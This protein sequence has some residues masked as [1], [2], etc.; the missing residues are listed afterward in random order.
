MSKGQSMMRVD[1]VVPTKKAGQQ[2]PPGFL[3][4]PFGWAAEPLAAMVNAERKLLADLFEMARPRMH[5]IALALA[6][7][8]P[9]VPPEI[10][11]LLSRGSARQVLDR[12]LGH[13]PAGIR[14]VLEHLP[15]EVLQR[16]NYQRLVHL[17]A[18]P[19]NAAVL[20]HADKIGDLAIQVLADLPKP[21]RRPLASA[22][23]DW[24]RKLNGLA[25]GLRLLVSRGVAS[26]FEELVAELATVTA[27][28]QLA[29]MIEFWIG[30]L[31]LPETMPPATVG[32]ARRLDRVDEVCSLARAWRNC[33]VS[34]G[35]A[36]DA[37]GCAVYLWEAEKPAACLARR[38]GRLGWFLDEVKGPQNVDIELEQLEIIEAAFANVAVP[39]SRVVSA[40]ENIIYGDAHGLIS[41]ED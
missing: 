1:D 39:R 18:D 16:Q 21:L 31:P 17:L 36:I 33:L 2:R 20:Y 6:H 19:E 9:P 38:Y 3:L 5:V 37:G 41:A 25:D 27:W 26:S 24:P 12:V 10:G 30:T 32:N 13:C 28:P 29:A 23:P 8:E 40:I 7:L 11:P 15:G 35:G 14:R 4:T 22:L 34:Y